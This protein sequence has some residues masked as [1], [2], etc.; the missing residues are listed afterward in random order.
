MAKT[1]FNTPIGPL[2]LIADVSGITEIK[3]IS[4][5]NPSYV[6]TEH[7]LFEEAKKQLTEYFEEKRKTFNLP[8]NPSGTP[9]QESVWKELQHIPFGTTTT[10]S[11]VSKK[12]D[13]PKA[14]RAVGKA[15]ALNPIPI[16]IPCHRVVG[17]NQTLTGYAGGI[18]RKRWL[19]KHE[20]ALLL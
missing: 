15:N 18:E 17:A 16:I 20:G 12:L 3:F 10:Y 2:L 19:L 4:N 7:P 13:N 1:T 8:V 6:K 9:F 14:V 11:E 5:E